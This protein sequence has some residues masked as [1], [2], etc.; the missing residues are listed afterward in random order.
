M[1]SALAGLLLLGACFSKPEPFTATVDAPSPFD[2]RVT[3]DANFMFTTSGRFAMG[4]T[5]VA[6][7]D[8]HCNAA[9]VAGGLPGHYLAWLSTSTALAKTRIQMTGARGWVRTDGRPFARTPNEIAAG[10]IFYP[11]R[12]DENG[13]DLVNLGLNSRV[14]TGTDSDLSQAADNCVNFTGPGMIRVGAFDAVWPF[15]TAMESL[16]CTEVTHLYCFGVDR[17]FDLPTVAP[18]GKL[19]FVTTM[20]YSPTSLADADGV[21]TTE[22]GGGLYRALIA[23]TDATARSRV[24]STGPYYRPDGMIVSVDLT[25]FIA[26]ISQTRAGVYQQKSV[27]FGAPDSTTNGNQSLNCGN[28]TGAGT[29]PHLGD[30]SRTDDS[31]FSTG[32]MN[33]C[34]SAHRVY[35][36]EN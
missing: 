26:P 2:A 4:A 13:T 3:T 28:W 20:A 16:D 32:G 33:S 22:G 30:S 27:W 21:C 35:C 25:T 11:P 34:G 5:S 24:T 14:A 6:E 15:W 1:R 10:K 29:S 9:A 18:A 19:A 8:A 12:L 23:P 7:A 17:A 31:M 36:I